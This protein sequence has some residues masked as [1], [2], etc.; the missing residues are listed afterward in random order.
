MKEKFIP[1]FFARSALLQSIYG[2][3]KLRNKGPNPMADAAEEVI[4]NGG[5]G[6]RLLGYYSRQQSNIPKGT[7]L[8]IHG[9]EGSSDS[10][11]VVS[12]GKYLFNRG[13]DIFR[14]NLRDHGDSHHLNKELFNS[15]MIDETFNAIKNAANL[16]KNKP[17]YIVG[18]SL[19]G[20]F[21]LRTALK[22]NKSKINN[23]KHIV[24]ISPVLDPEKSCIA[25]DKTLIIRKY[26][27][28]KWKRSLFKKQ[29]L[30]PHMYNFKEIKNMNTICEITDNF[31]PEY[32][33]FKDSKEYYSKYTLLDDT[34]LKLKT[35]VTIITSEDDPLI[36][37][38]D[39]YNLKTNK[40]LKLMIQPYGGHNGFFDFFPY[41]CWYE[42]KLYEIFSE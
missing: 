35:P 42:E 1:K 30:F 40:Y 12:T 25:T 27:L 11:Y 18:Y 4:L 41:K 6:V 33:E 22:Y 24:S 26:F 38:Q 34:F 23:L 3:I 14:L 10:S 13:F 8:F 37:V 32:T 17:F 29:A 5:K 21:A 7:V 39:F 2:S 16:R 36:P 19:G 31:V 15:S 9:W 20:N 28:K